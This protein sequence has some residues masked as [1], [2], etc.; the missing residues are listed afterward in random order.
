GYNVPN[1]FYSASGQP[2][3]GNQQ[4]VEQYISNIGAPAG[5]SLLPLVMTPD[6]AITIQGTPVSGNVLT[7]DSDPN[8]GTLTASL[9]SAPATGTVVINPD[10]SY[11]YTPPAGFTGT[12]T[13]CY[14]ATSTAGLS[15]SSC[16]SV[17]VFPAPTT[18]NNAPVANNDATQTTA[19]LSLTINVLANDTDP[20]GVTGLNGQL[21]IPTLPGQPIQGTAT[22][23]PT[24]GIVT[25]SP[26]AGFTGVVT[27]TYQV[28]D[29]GTPALCSTAVVSV[30]VLPSPP[31]GTTLSPIAVDDALITSLNTSVTG[32]VAANDRDPNTPA[33]PLTFTSGQP[34]HGSVVMSTGGVFTFT[35]VTGY[36]GPDSFTYLVCNSAGLCRKATVSIYV[37]PLVN[38]SPQV[39]PDVNTF[40]PG[41]PTAGNVLTNDK[42]P[43]GGGLTATVAGTPP[44]GFTLTP[45]G[46]YTYN[47]PVNQTTPVTVVINV[48][49]TGTPPACTTSTLTLVPVSPPNALTNDAPVALNDAVRTTAGVATT[50]NVLANDKDPEGLPL[51][52]PVLV[53]GPS[54][55]TAVVNPDGTVSYTPSAGFVGADG[56][57]YQVCD[58]GTPP[59]CS[60]AGVT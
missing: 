47:A 38:Q 48:C 59:A 5:C 14:T 1:S 2:A 50:V 52:N 27:F 51:S 4:P 6:I 56:L 41:L 49:D 37:N 58:T 9:L 53:S 30:N 11:L 8:G 42:D 20:D 21:G 13:F 44:A 23:D 25:Y 18:G 34:A 54:H 15:G 16:V 7:N 19:G 26:P 24:T 60:T 57:V 17:N 40:I 12:A 32:T 31:A 28:C 43:E 10:G 3:G 22:V 35:P 46:S 45:D 39:N 55:G 36:V 29:K 33:L